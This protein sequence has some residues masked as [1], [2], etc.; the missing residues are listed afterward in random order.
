MLVVAFLVGE[1]GGDSA[2]APT[3]S[4]APGPLT[5]TVPDLDQATAAICDPVMA[6]MPVTLDDGAGTTVQ[7][8]VVTPGGPSFLA[9][10]NPL[11]TIQCGVAR[12]DRL[13]DDISYEPQVITAPNGYGATWIAEESGD[14][15]TWSVIDRS[16]YFRAELPTGD[17]GYLTQ[18][19][20][21]I[22]EALPPVCTTP[23][24]GD[25]PD[26]QYCGS[27]P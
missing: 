27:R 20:A 19:S 6:A 18:L 12:P 4:A 16:V 3:P 22:G 9:W 13:R 21:V 23:Q 11:V 5:T 14:R 1:T 10:G 17:P 2:A 8:L 7:P 15:V 24:P 25:G 26:V